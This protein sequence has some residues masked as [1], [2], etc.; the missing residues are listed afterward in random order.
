MF[1]D[2]G[3]VLSL[4]GQKIGLDSGDAS[5]CF[6]SHAHSDHTQ[7]LKAR[8]RKIIAS[9]ETLA[10]AGFQANGNLVETPAVLD[11]VELKMLESGHVLGAKQL[12]AEHDGRVFAYTGDFKLRDGLTTKKAEVVECDTLLIEGT[13]GESGT[14]FPDRMLVFEEMKKWVDEGMENGSVLFGGYAIGKAQELVKFL[15]DYCR[16]A[17]LVSG[18]IEQACRVYEKFGVKL[19]CVSASSAEGEELKKKNFTA[20]LPHY[21]V[22]KGLAAKLCGVYG[23]PFRTALATGWANKRMFDVD[24][25]FP[26]SDHADFA[27]IIEYVEASKAKE[28]I[29]CHGNEENLARELRSRG[30]NARA[31]GE[32]MQMRLVSL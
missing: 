32:A 15:N 13:Y 9:S 18:K 27:E 25:V 23:K 17:P 16:V 4:G 28:I 2:E 10:L 19:D 5:V 6:V 11:E 30:H 7:P 1:V 12:R 8:G 26:I 20:V 24:E 21:Q 31:R 29:C 14:I 3:N 22:E